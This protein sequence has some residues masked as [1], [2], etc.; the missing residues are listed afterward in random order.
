MALV[1]A[2]VLVSIIIFVSYY[3]IPSIR[4]T[5]FSFFTTYL[6]N[7]GFAFKPPVLVHGVLAPAGSSFGLN[8]FLLGTLTTSLLAILIAFPISFLISLNIELFLPKKTKK[9]MISMIELFAGIPSVVYGLWGIIILE[10]VLFSSIEPWMA[11][12]LSFIPGFKGE[13]YSGAGLIASGIILS[14]MITPIITSVVVN[15]FDSVPKNVKEGL[16]SLGATKWEVGKYLFMGYSKAS[17][18]G[19]TLLGLGRAL[20]E[21]MAVLMVS[22]AVVNTLPTSI[23]SATNTMAAAIASLLDSAFF[24]STGMNISALAEL[25]LVLMAISLAVS[26]LGR[27]IAGRGALRGY[28]SD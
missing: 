2:G 4:Y 27:K 5:S 23:Y 11:N 24:D 13:I 22:G 10:P 21:T 6:W 8:L 12:H 18:V 9:F 20:G 16:Y 26:L 1:P 28:E 7:P 25:A 19:G 14:F 3:S 15:S 17:T